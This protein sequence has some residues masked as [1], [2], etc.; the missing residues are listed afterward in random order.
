MNFFG[1]SHGPEPGLEPD[2]QRPPALVAAGIGGAGPSAR[3]APDARA[4]SPDLLPRLVQLCRG[5]GAHPFLEPL[6]ETFAVV[7]HALAAASRAAPEG[8]EAPEA[9]GLADAAAAA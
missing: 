7:D 6:G 8:P 2:S 1:W 4:A 9:A 5:P 3:G